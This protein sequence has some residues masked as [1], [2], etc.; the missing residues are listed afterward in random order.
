MMWKTRIAILVLG[1]VV[2]FAVAATG[3]SEEVGVA[4]T[5]SP[6][7]NPEGTFPIV[8]EPIT[9][10][11]FIE[12]PSTVP[13][14]EQNAF[15]DWLTQKTNI[16]LSIDAPIADA[17][18]R[19]SV[20]L[21]SGDYPEVLMTQGSGLSPAQQF[22][23]GSQGV[24]LPLNDFI[25]DYGV[26]TRGVFSQ[27]P[28]VRRNFTMPDGNVYSLPRIA[29]QLHSSMSMKAWVYE[30]WLDAL[31]L[32]MP[33][34]TDE[35]RDVL[36]AFRDGDPNG[37]GDS[38]DEIPFA[39]ST[40]WQGGLDGFLMNAF[41]YTHENLWSGAR[42][43]RLRI[44]DG[45]V[46][47][48]YDED[49]FRQGLMYIA[50]LYAEG[51]VAPESLVQDGNQFRQMGEN[52]GGPILGVALAGHQMGFTTVGGESGR[53]LEFVTVPPLEGPE[54]VRWTHLRPVD[55]FAAFNI[56]DHAQNPAAAF[57]LGD[58]FAGFEG[59]A[60]NYWGREGIEW[61]YAEPGVL[62]V[63]GGQALWQPLVPRE[64]IPADANW[65]QVGPINRNDEFE[66]GRAA[67]PGVDP[68]R[69][70]ET[71]LYLETYEKYLPYAPSVDRVLPPLTFPDESIA[72]EYTELRSSINEYVNE[73]VARFI[74]GD[75]DINRLWGSYLD[76]LDKIGLQRYLE[77]VQAAYD[78]WVQ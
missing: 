78:D 68:S 51:L 39:G 47:A 50:G 58:L 71:I 46:D 6:S 32:D 30:P 14:Y 62:G 19:R 70:W 27:Y 63:T 76:E 45:V 48:I 43:D 16:A 24:L 5:A 74:V 3:Q 73:M 57:R 42:A 18:Q 1:L 8:D 59:T 15:A 72:A 4:Q 29:G 65:A 36:I 31:D 23:Y 37:N 66:S 69:D 64:S 22:L 33:T 20:M 52:P 7:V 77:I 41:I 11:M 12:G 35:F 54:G 10:S 2:A 75:A 53:W 28:R 13:D 44:V 25:D 49:E 26:N 21:A 34:T 56:T 61:E 40:W 38:S 67:L 9:I 17:G 55:G 60:R